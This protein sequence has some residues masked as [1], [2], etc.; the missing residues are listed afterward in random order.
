MS[1]KS[2]T[3]YRLF[4]ATSTAFTQWPEGLKSVF[5]NV[6]NGLAGKSGDDR[7]AN[8]T[9]TW[10]PNMDQ[11]IDGQVLTTGC[12]HMLARVEDNVKK[13]VQS[14]LFCAPIHVPYVDE[15]GIERTTKVGATP[16]VRYIPE[17]IY[18]EGAA[19][20]Q[21]FL[22]GEFG[23]TDADVKAGEQMRKGKGSVK[24]GTL[25]KLSLAELANFATETGVENAESLDMQA[26]ELH[27]LSNSPDSPMNQA[28]EAQATDEDVNPET[29]EVNEDG[30]E[31]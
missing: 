12:A 3:H 17:D 4:I 13:D 24:R 27:W 28:A 22:Y 6:A 26:L 2:I 25:S 30:D 9:Q 8:Y 1:L 11:V 29:G 31:G 18:Q 21:A 23:I 10:N 5:K 15:D 20:V 7:I 19:A 14:G 16:R